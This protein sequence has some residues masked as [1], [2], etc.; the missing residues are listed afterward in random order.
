MLSRRMNSALSSAVLLAGSLWLASSI[1][2]AADIDSPTLNAVQERGRVVCGVNANLPG[3]STANSLGEYAGLDIDMCRAISAAVF[4]DAEQTEYV[5]TSATDRFDALNNNEFDVL[6]RNTTWTLERNASFGNFAGVNYYDGQGF[7]VWKR[8]GIRSA[9]ELDNVSICV[10]RGTT[11]ELNAADYFTINKIR[12]A[13]VFF[14]DSSTAIE[15]YSSGECDALTTDRSALAAT[16]ISQPDPE[17]HRMLA[18]IISKE[19][20]G[21]MVRVNDTGWENVVRWSLNCMINA[22]EI[23]IDSANVGDID[24]NDLPNAQRL[25]G[26]VGDFGEKLGLN[27]SWCADIISSV[28]NYAESYERNV[29]VDSRLDLPRGVNSLWTNGGLIYA[30]P[31]R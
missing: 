3:F 5:P 31:I 8:S 15:A 22:E 25:K 6:T 12:Y 23:G 20:L 16:R 29:G 26:I 7:M 30:P 28:G 11:T 2:H 4:G 10:T 27:D 19:P 14:D 18:E 1:S 13:P 9:L 21:P 24:D 17:A